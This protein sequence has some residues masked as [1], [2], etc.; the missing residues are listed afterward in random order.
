MTFY[1]E[2]RRPYLH[3]A[4]DTASGVEI[5]M[6]YP[7]DNGIQYANQFKGLDTYWRG[8]YGELPRTWHV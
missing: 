4:C 2:L 1:F 8:L 3:W 7:V 6:V 5:L